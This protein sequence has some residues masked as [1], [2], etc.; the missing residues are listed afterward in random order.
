M[1]TSSYSREPPPPKRATPQNASVGE[2]VSLPSGNPH[3]ARKAKLYHLPGPTV[4]ELLQR[5]NGNAPP[6]KMIGRKAPGTNGFVLACDAVPWKSSAQRE[7]E[8]VESMRQQAKEEKGRRNSSQLPP[9]FATSSQDVDKENAEGRRDVCDGKKCENVPKNAL[10]APLKTRVNEADDVSKNWKNDDDDD[11][12]DFVRASLTPPKG[13]EKKKSGDDKSSGKRCVDVRVG[14]A[15]IHSIRRHSPSPASS[16]AGSTAATAIAT[17]AGTGVAGITGAAAPSA[18][19]PSSASGSTRTPRSPSSSSATT[20][21]GPGAVSGTMATA[22]G[23]VST[24]VT[25]GVTSVA[26]G[27]VFTSLSLLRA[28][29]VVAGGGGDVGGFGCAWRCPGGGSG[30][31]DK[32]GDRTTWERGALLAEIGDRTT[33]GRTSG[34][35]VAE[36]RLPTKKKC[37]KC[38]RRSRT[39]SNM[40][41]GTIPEPRNFSHARRRMSP[42]TSWASGQWRKRCWRSMIILVLKEAVL[43]EFE[44]EKGMKESPGALKN[45]QTVGKPTGAAGPQKTITRFTGPPPQ[46]SEC[47]LRLKKKP[48]RTRGVYAYTIYI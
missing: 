13:G 34:V 45:P 22:T 5:L 30:N 18:A 48:S 4:D 47:L 37:R 33:C 16:K 31:G 9:S 44:E 14:S 21:T 12:A 11:D 19:V 15:V 25:T 27:G 46:A 35:G 39:T 41:C 1:N 10:G 40:S 43:G 6:T 36:V 20:A 3:L 8:K 29:R 26:C 32:I 2:K 17:G 38:R 42:T 7:A 23:S 28:V 24:A